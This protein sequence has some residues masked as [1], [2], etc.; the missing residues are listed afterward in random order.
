MSKI[1]TR[2]TSYNSA[3]VKQALVIEETS[4]TRK[5]FRA[6][7]ND[8]KLV[9]GE[10]VSGVIVHQRKGK[11]DTWEDEESIDLKYTFIVHH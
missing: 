9:K 10:T 8:I 6:F 2:S 1:T 5:I 7:I 11:N 3:E 4:T